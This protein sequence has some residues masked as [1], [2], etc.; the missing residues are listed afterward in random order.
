[1]MARPHLQKLVER[2]RLLPAL[3][4][5]ASDLDRASDILDGVFAAVAT[6]VHA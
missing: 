1:M 2:A 3:N 4:I 5:A 6:E